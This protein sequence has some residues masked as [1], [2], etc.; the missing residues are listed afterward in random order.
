MNIVSYLDI[1]EN[2]APVVE[3]L[4]YSHR[5]GKIFEATKYRNKIRT[6]YTCGGFGP[7]IVPVIFRMQLEIL[8]LYELLIPYEEK[9]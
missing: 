6:K 8:E 2:P 4:Y 9:R 3:G 5:T 7:A 1:L